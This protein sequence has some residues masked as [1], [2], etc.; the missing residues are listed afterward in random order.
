MKKI[1]IF[2]LLMLVYSGFSQNE[3]PTAQ[4]ISDQIA[5]EIKSFNIPPTPVFKI[6]N[7][8]ITIKNNTVNIRI[9][10]PANTKNSTIIFNIHGGALVGGD[11]ETHDNVSRLLC[12]KTNAV[13]VALDYKKPSQNPYP[14]SIL[15]CEQVL[16]WIK[17]NAKSIGGNA[18]KIVMLGDSGGG[19][20]CA[21]LAT[22][23]TTALKVQAMILVNPA[24]DLRTPPEGI[25]ALVT[26]MYLGDTNPNN[27]LV[28][29]LMETNFSY[30]PKTLIITS[31]KDELKPHGDALFAKLK[32]AQKPVE[33]LDLENQDHLGGYWAAAHPDAKKALVKVID[34][35]QR[36]K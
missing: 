18:Q 25:Y 1:I 13:V 7:K 20:L 15:D 11:L 35:I 6:E 36:L 3:M 28:S 5:G 9:Y 14:A 17:A 34:Y 21:S 8:A 2:T 32:A 10:Q 26:A 23:L 22:K 29:P 30:F 27:V 24:L 19:L 12:A 16:N 31:Q 4:Q 33:I